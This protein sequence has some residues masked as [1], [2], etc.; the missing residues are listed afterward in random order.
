MEVS[1]R[2]G[3]LARALRRFLAG[4]T[5]ILGA[6]VLIVPGS[7]WA[8]AETEGADDAAQVEQIAAGDYDYNDDGR[9]DIVARRN[10]TGNLEIW[11]GN[12]AFGFGTKYSAGG[13]WNSMNLIETAGDLNQ[14]GHADLIAREASTG[15]LWYYRGNGT[16]FSPRQSIGSGWQV[17]SAIVAGHD[18]NGDEFDDIIATELGTGTLWLYPGT[19]MGPAFGQRFA[20]GSSFHLVE[21]LTAVGDTNE[22]GRADIVGVSTS[23]QCMYFYAGPGSEGFKPKVLMDCGWDVMEMAAAVGNFDSD[24]HADWVGREADTGLLYLFRGSGTGGISSSPVIDSGW[25]SMTIA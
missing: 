20:I 23:N 16:T 11:P 14:D 4:S 1:T 10:S 7:S 8:Q 3:P 9:D 15:I 13:G 22:D 17:M 25:G 5:G 18:Y 2:R 21:D 19:G 24:G 12:G 6:A